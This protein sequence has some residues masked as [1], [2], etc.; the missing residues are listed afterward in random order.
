MTKEEESQ[1]SSQSSSNLDSGEWEHANAEAATTFDDRSNSRH[2]DSSS[3]LSSFVDVDGEDEFLQDDT[4][5]EAIVTKTDVAVFDEGEVSNPDSGEISGNHV[6]N[7]GTGAEKELASSSVFEEPKD[8]VSEKI[9]K[10][11]KEL[12][13][14][15]LEAN[16]TISDIDEDEENEIVDS[17]VTED[18]TVK[19]AERGLPS[20]EKSINTEN[21]VGNEVDDLDDVAELKNDDSD[22][23]TFVVVGANDNEENEIPTQRND[24]ISVEK[25]VYTAPVQEMLEQKKREHDV[26]K[27]TEIMEMNQRVKETEEG[28]PSY[29]NPQMP[30]NVSVAGK[31]ESNA[32]SYFDPLSQDKTETRVDPWAEPISSYPQGS[33]N[34][35]V[36]HPAFTKENTE[37][38]YESHPMPAMTKMNLMPQ[39]PRARVEVEMSEMKAEGENNDGVTS[40]PT[41]GYPS[42]KNLSPPPFPTK[43]GTINLGERLTTCGVV[44]LVFGLFFSL[45]AETSC[46]FATTDILVGYYQSRFNG[47]LGLWGYEPV[48]SVLM[49]ANYCVS[50]NNEYSASA[51]PHLSRF[52]GLVAI[53]LGSCS[54]AVVWAYLL[55]LEY[56]VFD[57][58]LAMKFA[59]AAAFFQ[60]LTLTFFLS[61]ACTEN[62]CYLGTGSLLSILA[63]F[64]WAYL[65]SELYHYLPMMQSQENSSM[66]DSLYHAPNLV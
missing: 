22:N 27:A 58:S 19:E 33:G 17:F 51:P 42:P 41:L 57:W 28:S 13:S 47:R 4:S 43:A 30:M 40:T 59:A 62:S 35:V 18:T 50:Y 48:D 56:K 31:N 63:V 16:A 37:K 45:F 10:D 20:V 46:N 55:K 5:E 61:D 23:S 60:L 11:L 32:M 12:E 53:V 15:E 54:L 3:A 8:I 14:K 6:E 38:N 34:S 24:M 29:L 21:D 65:A 1:S 52:A 2:T 44:G 7:D 64:A 49:G 39:T 66:K 9:E 26:A 36:T 25:E